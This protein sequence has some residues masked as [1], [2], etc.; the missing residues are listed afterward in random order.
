MIISPM[1]IPSN[2]TLQPDYKW[3]VICTRYM[4]IYVD[5]AWIIMTI[6]ADIDVTSLS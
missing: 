4:Y 3:V 1:I 2:N 5:Y 6:I